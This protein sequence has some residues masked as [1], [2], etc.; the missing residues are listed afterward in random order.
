MLLVKQ[1]V[2]KSCA[3]L[4]FFPLLLLMSQP[5]MADS[6]ANSPD[7][8]KM[9]TSLIIVLG[10]IFML[11]FLVKRFNLTGSGAGDIKL[12]ATLP[13]GTKERLVVVEIEQQQYVLGVTSQQIS[14]VEKLSQPLSSKAPSAQ[15]PS[16]LKFDSLVNFIKK[17]NL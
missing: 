14:L 3:K 4:A 17:G 7:Y 13:L 1:N 11:A 16:G 12:I 6:L 2:L 5:A 9:I 15:L 8:I 10:I